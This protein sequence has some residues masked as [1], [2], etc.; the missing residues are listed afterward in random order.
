MAKNDES[1]CG[2][3]T[4]LIMVIDTIITFFSCFYIFSASDGKTNISF[5]HLKD[6]V[7]FS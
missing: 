2:V 1:K 3:Q 6:N 5:L 7:N 4:L